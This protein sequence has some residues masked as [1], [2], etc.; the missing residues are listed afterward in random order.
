MCILSAVT[1]IG[2][3][4]CSVWDENA[5][6]EV[7]HMWYDSLCLCAVFPLPPLASPASAVYLSRALWESSAWGILSAVQLPLIILMLYIPEGWWESTQGHSAFCRPGEHS[8]DRE[9][10]KCWVVKEAWWDEGE[11]MNCI[12]PTR[13]CLLCLYTEGGEFTKGLRKILRSLDLQK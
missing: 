7:M 12:E 3:A 4:V 6:F 1:R 11:W 8:A 9:R 13:L 10:V 2:L 5:L